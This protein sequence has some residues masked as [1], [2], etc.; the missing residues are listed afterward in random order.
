M[1]ISIVVLLELFLKSVALFSDM[2][3]MPKNIAAKIMW[4]PLVF[5]LL[6]WYDPTVIISP[7]KVI[8]IEFLAAT[9]NHNV[10]ILFLEFGFILEYIA[11]DL[12]HLQGL[13]LVCAWL[14]VTANQ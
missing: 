2:V 13:F 8:G 6:R 5:E 7:W 10:T 14:T 12:S 4:P 9:H 1:I 3:S 11:R